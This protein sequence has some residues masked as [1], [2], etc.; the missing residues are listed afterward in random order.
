MIPAMSPPTAI[1]RVLYNRTGL[2]RLRLMSPANIVLTSML[3]ITPA[4]IPLSPT[5]VVIESDESST[6]AVVVTLPLEI[7]PPMN[8]MR[9][10]PPPPN[11]VSIQV[12][13]MS[14]P[15]NIVPKTS[16][17][18][19]LKGDWRS[20]M[21]SSWSVSAICRA[22]PAPERQIASNGGPTSIAINGTNKSTITAFLSA[23]AELA[24]TIEL[25]ASPLICEESG[26]FFSRSAID[27]TT[28]VELT[29][30]P[31]NPVTINP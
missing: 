21:S 26:E 16:A 5:E 18:L 29:N 19:R 15:R 27:A 10:N 20:S 7:R 13:V 1:R 3:A 9:I 23:I 2:M 6:T 4:R 12:E 24:R 31:T 22:I 28:A 25:V 30:P 8:E 11:C 17:F 14:S